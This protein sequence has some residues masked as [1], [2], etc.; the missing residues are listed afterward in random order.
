MIGL[1]NWIL[2]AAICFVGEMITTSFFLLWFG[3]GA[4]VAAV[5]T[6]FGFAPK[7]QLIAFV[8]VSGV[9]VVASRQIAKRITKEPPK[10]AVSDRLIGKKGI[11]IGEISPE[12]SGV[13][14]MQDDTWLAISDQKIEEGEYVVVEGIEGVK[15]VVKPF[16]KVDSNKY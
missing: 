15:L 16:K 13:V 3:V 9:L 8:V 10:K 5:L 12:A 4:A 14:R 11:V 7:I 1:Q 6:Y 2:L